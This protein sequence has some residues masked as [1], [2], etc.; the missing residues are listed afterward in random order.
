[1]IETPNVSLSNFEG[2][3]DLLLYL[4]QRE[5]ID[6]YDI[7]LHE[8]TSQFL[9]ELNAAT[10][11]LD[12]GAEFLGSTSFL[13]LLKSERLLPV[14]EKSE[15]EDE[16]TTLTL[17][18]DLIEYCSFKEMAKRLSLVEEKASGHF[19]RGKIPEIDLKPPLAPI[20]HTIE[21]L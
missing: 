14:L 1:M 15:R 5:E 3:L 13:L 10:G 18:K 2:P 12:R 19:L 11:R 4:I 8:V 21:D 17:L 20:S 7:P 6:V 9:S 16:N